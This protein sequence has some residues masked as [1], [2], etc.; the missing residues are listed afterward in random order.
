MD[1]N[2]VIPEESPSFHSWQSLRADDIIIELKEYWFSQILLLQTQHRWQISDSNRT[3]E[4]NILEKWIK[5]TIM[6]PQQN[7]NSR[8]YFL[9]CGE[10]AK[11][12]IK[13][14]QINIHAN[15]HSPK[16]RCRKIR[17]CIN[18]LISS[19][20]IK[21]CMGDMCDAK[22]KLRNFEWNIKFSCYARTEFEKHRRK[23]PEGRY[24]IKINFIEF[25]F[26]VVF[27]THTNTWS[28]TF[29]PTHFMN[30]LWYIWGM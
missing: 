8:Q 25:T 21:A 13:T 1:G 9:R 22:I 4:K 28:S 27:I 6:M 26:L 24:F 7:T 15:F 18:I 2:V 29:S 23:M 3:N 20:E 30:L 11:I 14:H 10:T 5:Y 12:A 16:R 19:Q 17:K